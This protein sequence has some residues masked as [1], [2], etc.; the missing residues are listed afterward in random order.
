MI[1]ESKIFQIDS[2]IFSSSNEGMI[3]MDTSILNLYNQGLIT[4][5]NALL[6]SRYPTIL[7]KKLL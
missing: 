6:Y 7:E 1:R 4:R 2:T 5:E 3:A